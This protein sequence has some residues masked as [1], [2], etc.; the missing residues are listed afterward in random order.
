MEPYQSPIDGRVIRNEQERQEDLRRHGCRPWEGLHD[1]RIEAD[2]QKAYS[3]QAAE[4]KIEDHVAAT[5]RNLPDSK[6][7]ALGY[8]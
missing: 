6:K 3:V 8:D 1:E 4:R 5:Y 2:R 7:A